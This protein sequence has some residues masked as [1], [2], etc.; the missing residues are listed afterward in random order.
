MEQIDRLYAIIRKLRGENGCP[1]DLEQKTESLVPNIIEE[2]YEVVEAIEK[3]DNEDLAE[4]LGDLFFLVL[5]TAYVAEQEGRLRV[6]DAVN[7]ISDKLVRR[8]PHVFGELDERSVD[9]IIENWE[10]IKRSEKK[11]ANRK[12]PFDGI[13]KGL[14]AIQRFNKVREKAAR[15]GY[16]AR[17]PGFD[18]VKAAFNVYSKKRNTK[19]LEEFL[20]LFLNYNYDSKIDLS[21]TIRALT[22]K[23]MVQYQ[24]NQVVSTRPKKR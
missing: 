9:R 19:N 20:D 10:M 4:E 3:G 23:N 15:A 5:F 24:K 13:P 16:G 17:K 18:E 8:H 7:G 21:R 12:T 2:A 14:P 1:W 22:D 6:E 11:N